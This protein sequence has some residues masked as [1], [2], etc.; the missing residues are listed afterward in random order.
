[1]R[2]W[3]K[4]YD[5]YRKDT[6]KFI[7]SPVTIVTLV[8]WR[9]DFIKLQ[10]DSLKKHL[11]DPFDYIVVNNAFNSL[12]RKNISMECKNLGIK[13]IRVKRRFF[14][15]LR[16]YRFA[17]KLFEW[18]KSRSRK[19]GEPQ[20]GMNSGVSRFKIFGRNLIFL[21]YRNVTLACSYGM[22]YI[23]KKIFPSL[24]SKFF[25]ILDSDM[26]FINDFSVS[27]NMEK[28]DLAFTPQYRG[29]NGQVYYAT[30]GFVIVNTEIVKEFASHD[31]RYGKIY[32]FSTDVGGKANNIVKEYSKK[33][34]IKHM[35][36]L[37]ILTSGLSDTDAEI[38]LSLT[39]D[40]SYNFDILAN[41]QGE[42]T[43]VYEGLESSS[44]NTFFPF[45]ESASDPEFLKYLQSFVYFAMK[46]ILSFDWP[47][48]LYIEFLPFTDTEPF[49]IHY[50]SGSNYQ[51]FAT[52]DYNYIKTRIVK[53]IL[54]N[55]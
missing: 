22:N 51:A 28:H 38:Q 4:F 9:P 49:L 14:L 48:P 18:S 21:Q 24:N 23:T 37:S 12:R 17:F 53:S 6:N 7:S 31:W 10:Y 2:I 19:L 42:I 20:Y 11:T 52:D 26:F 27:K 47:K 35:H 41:L 34:R 55:S 40:G 33:Y 8:D 32:G 25:M 44:L 13:E 43:K 15:S 29:H 3:K 50:K 36:T 16:E 5:Y 54:D 1:M 30:N 46:F 39:L 45:F